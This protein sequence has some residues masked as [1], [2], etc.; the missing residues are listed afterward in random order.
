MQ[1]IRKAAGA[2]LLTLT[3]NFIS[4]IGESLRYEIN[5][6][7]ETFDDHAG[8]YFSYTKVNVNIKPFVKGLFPLVKYGR[9]SVW[10]LDEDKIERN[11]S[12]SSFQKGYLCYL[13]S[14]VITDKANFSELRPQHDDVKFKFDPK[15]K[16]E[17]GREYAR[18]GSIEIKVEIYDPEGHFLALLS[19]GN[20]EKDSFN[21]PCK[22]SGA[23][24]NLLPNMP[25]E[26]EYYRK[27]PKLFHS[28]NFASVASDGTTSPLSE[29]LCIVQHDENVKEAAKRFS[30]EHKLG[31]K[32][33]KY[34]EDEL[35]KVIQ[36]KQGRRQALRKVIKER[37]RNGK[38][39]NV[40]FGATFQQTEEIIHYFDTSDWIPLTIND[41]DML[42]EDDFR[43][44]FDP[45]SSFGTN[46]IEVIDAVMTEHVFE[47]LNVVDAIYALKLLTK[48]LKNDGTCAVRRFVLKSGP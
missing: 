17:K 23:R 35:S 16:I 28:F 44:F 19:V 9:Y 30:N 21:K 42:S 20:I 33:E 34:V 47:H 5:L 2:I 48:Y 29:N 6:C 7:K 14:Q 45:E 26:I 24:K 36:I 11:A 12:Q 18:L 39:I 41:F 25:G 4:V 10:C 31:L 37:I 8:I 22:F 40:V 15:G 32:H 46:S 3:L 27:R 13:P 1:S 38:K 43:Y